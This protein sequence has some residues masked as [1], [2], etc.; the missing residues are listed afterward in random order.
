MSENLRRN[1]KSGLGIASDRV[2]LEQYF[3]RDPQVQSK[4]L[5]LLYHKQYNVILDLQWFNYYGKPA[6]I[7]WLLLCTSRQYTT[8]IAINYNQFYYWG[9]DQDKQHKIKIISMKT[10]RYLAEL[11]KSGSVTCQHEGMRKFHRDL[12]LH[13]LPVENPSVHEKT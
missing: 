11:E 3:C 12:M 7:I 10:S 8:I 1:R 4:N 13:F 5:K 9:L 2:K 6:V